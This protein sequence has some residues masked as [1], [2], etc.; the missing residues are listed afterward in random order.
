VKNRADDKLVNRRARR[1]SM[2]ALGG[3]HVAS[4]AARRKFLLM[5]SPRV[6]ALVAGVGLVD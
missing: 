3:R 2:R 1:W 4:M 5:K 6:F